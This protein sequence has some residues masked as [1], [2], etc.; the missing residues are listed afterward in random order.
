MEQKVKISS[1][2][3]ALKAFATGSGYRLLPVEDWS[4]TIGESG[5]ILLGAFVDHAN[6]LRYIHFEKIQ[7]ES[8]DGGGVSEYAPK[9]A[10][11]LPPYRR[12]GVPSSW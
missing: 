10:A 1:D 4:L 3:S 9:G 2:V 7:P 8:G 6:H 5:T 11:D 12:F